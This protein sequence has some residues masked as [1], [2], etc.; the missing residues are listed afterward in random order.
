M[1]GA[2]HTLLAALLLRSASAVDPVVISTWFPDAVQAAYDVAAARMP[3][4]EAVDAG[5]SF[6]EAHQCDGT[7][8]V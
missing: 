3:A 2:V 8:G 6:C 5:C 4:L 7:V 1:A